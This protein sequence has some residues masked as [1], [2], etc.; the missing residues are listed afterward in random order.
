ME[1]EVIAALIGTPAVL[2]TALAGWLAGR[3]Q[4]HGTYHGAVDAARREA[5]SQAY[6][7]LYRTTRSFIDIYEDALRSLRGAP[8][9]GPNVPLPDAF[10]QRVDELHQL[11]D[12]VEQA[13]DM[14]RLVGPDNLAEIAERIWDNARKLGGH[15]I[16]AERRSVPLLDFWMY[17]PASRDWHE[18]HAAHD[19]AVADFR[20]ARLELLPA[21]RKYL[22]G[23]PS[24]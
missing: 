20:S 18:A 23:G 19:R 15:R 11:V 24:Q 6:A 1:S 22:N 5:Q 4:S 9:A 7:D 10:R 13:A 16:T 17:A 8:T 3:T 14:V 21:A 12:S 2:V